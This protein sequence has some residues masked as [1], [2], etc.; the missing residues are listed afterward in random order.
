M[1]VKK[2]LKKYYLSKIEAQKVPE[3]GEKLQ[4]KLE[5]TTPIKKQGTYALNLAFH[6]GLI[7]LLVLFLVLNS[8][9]P[10]SLQKL[11]PDNQKSIF[12]QQKFKEGLDKIKNYFRANPVPVK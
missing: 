4:K 11:D 2:Q 12:V 6:A 7:V 1:S 10:R 5:K 9:T 8:N 3:L